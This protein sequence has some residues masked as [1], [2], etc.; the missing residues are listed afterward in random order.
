V[1]FVADYKLARPGDPG[2][3]ETLQ[4]LFEAVR[5]IRRHA[6][7]FRVDP[8][9]L[10]A[11]GSGA[12]G[13]LAA[14]LGTSAATLPGEPS[15][16]VQA[17]VSLY[18]PSDLEELIRHR[19]LPNDPAG[20][21]LGDT[22]I[23]VGQAAAFSPIKQISRLVP[24]MLLIHGTDDAWVPPEQSRRLADALAKAGVRHRL[25]EVPGARHGFE[26]EVGFPESRDLV[27][28]VL[29]FLESVWQVHLGDQP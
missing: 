20:V 9:R 28:D 29:A 22:R 23:G 11:L 13:H 25:I 18:G 19:G 4:D 2:W 3:P 12:G 10:A 1:V 14:L 8:D 15:A 17:V 27:P 7:E 16:R 5:W 21:F 6:D 26:L 24:P